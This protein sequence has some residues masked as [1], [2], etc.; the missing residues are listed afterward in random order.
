MSG[1]VAVTLL[2]LGLAP[3]LVA[4]LYATRETR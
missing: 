2:A 1:R 4:A 3:A